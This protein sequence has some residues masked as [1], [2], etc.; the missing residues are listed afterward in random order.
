MRLQLTLDELIDSVRVVGELLDELVAGDRA[1]GVLRKLAARGELDATERRNL[2]WALLGGG[3]DTTSNMIG[4]GTLALLENPDQRDLLLADPELVDNAVEELL[5]YL[6]ISQFGAS[7]CALEDVTVG[8]RL[9]REGETVV[10][11]L[12]AANRD[13]GRSPTPTGSTSPATYAGT[14]RSGT[15][16]TSASASTSP[17]RRCGWRTR[18]C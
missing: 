5:R 12:P 16:C 14:W 1:T 10:V 18:P 6:T 8:G 3:T 2:A 9:V 13:A 17:A 7:R 15:A 4:L 11:A